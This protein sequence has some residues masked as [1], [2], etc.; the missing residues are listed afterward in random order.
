MGITALNP[1]SSGFGVCSAF[2][3]ACSAVPSEAS[4]DSVFLQFAFVHAA[5]A[6]HFKTQRVTMK[7]HVAQLEYGVLIHT[8]HCSA[9]L[10]AAQFRDG[11]N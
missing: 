2:G 4:P 7:R 8:V 10:A 3:T 11:H 9:K 6:R 5:H 1:G